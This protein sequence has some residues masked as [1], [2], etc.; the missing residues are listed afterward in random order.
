[1][2]PVAYSRIPC[3]WNSLASLR[4]H[5]V[6][7]FRSESASLQIITSNLS[8]VGTGCIGPGVDAPL[9]LYTIS[10]GSFFYFLGDF[11]NDL[12]ITSRRTEMID[13]R[14][15]FFELHVYSSKSDDDY[16]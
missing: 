10:L 8:L 7:Y 2:D 9:L 16:Y 11:G 1:M 5:I 3:T 13:E 15:G 4:G 12:A 14:D 6:P